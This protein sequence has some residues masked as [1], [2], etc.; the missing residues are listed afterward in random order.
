MGPFTGIRVLGTAI[1][2]LFQRPRLI[3]LGMVPPLI[4]TVVYVIAGLFVIPWI[5][6]TVPTA[7]GAWMGAWPS[8]LVTVLTFAMMIVTLAALALIAGVAFTTLT[9]AIGGPIYD[10]I[11]QIIDIEVLGVEEIVEDGLGV[12]VMRSISQSVVILALSLTVA[13]ATLIIG[14]IPVIGTASS[15]IGGLGLG[16]LLVTTELLGGPFGRRGLPDLGQR[17]AAMKANPVE[18][19]SFGVP[20]QF[21][22]SIPFVGVLAFPFF[23][24]GAS[25]LAHK[26]LTS[27]SEESHGL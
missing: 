13:L 10:R 23:A 12:A 14:L 26:L 11:S 2:E 21:V 22:L 24:A 7:L 4:V 17:W 19:I 20:A 9:L 15:L 27:T 5:V 8:W 16:G 25:V 1:H 18:V 6:D 3:I